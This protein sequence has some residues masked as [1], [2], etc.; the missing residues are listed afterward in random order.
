MKKTF[1]TILLALSFTLT[2][3]G[4]SSEKAVKDAYKEMG[5]ED[6]EINELM[7]ELNGEDKAELAEIYSEM[8]E[9]ES[10]NTSEEVE[11][12]TKEITFTMSDTIKNAKLSDGII[13][14]YDMIFSIDGSMSIGEAVEVLENSS[15]DLEYDIPKE[16]M[17][18]GYTEFH[19]SYDEDML[20]T[21]IATIPTD[22]NN[23][24]TYDGM[25][26]EIEYEPSLNREYIWLPSGITFGDDM[27][28]VEKA[29]IDNNLTNDSDVTKYHY[30][31]NGS[32]YIATVP[33]KK[34]NLSGNRDNITYHIDID[35][36]NK[37][38]KSVRAD[39]NDSKM[40]D[41]AKALGYL[42]N[43]TAITS[44]EQIT[45]EVI[46]KLDE[47]DDLYIGNE[48]KA[49][50]SS[51]ITPTSAKLYAIAIEDD[52][53]TT[54]IVSKCDTEDGLKYIDS[55][56]SPIYVTDTGE[57]FVSYCDSDPWIVCSD[58]NHATAYGDPLVVE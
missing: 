36:S 3:C 53:Y 40:A 56:L 13:Q 33:A 43:A 20:F 26:S 42:N 51:P 4:N 7:N 35:T 57:I 6:N 14:I 5:L 49:S 2:A 19:V 30:E 48:V 31:L 47:F 18:T 16:G 50:F 11:E 28:T 55:P 23:V 24:D 25:L 15:L 45:D 8:A 39:G 21:F 32:S 29:F 17:I 38:V 52:D 1:V 58:N 22:A 34:K 9:M 54:W 12:D 46:A 41:F 37:T 44:K 27:D 10:D